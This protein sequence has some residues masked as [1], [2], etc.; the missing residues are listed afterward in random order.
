MKK[1]F[2]ETA[3][4]TRLYDALA[5]LERRGADECNLMVVDGEP[6][7]GKTTTLEWW[8]AQNNLIFLRALKE[9]TPGWFLDDL[10]A[11]M[12]IAAP[13][14]F[15]NRYH[16]ALEGLVTRQTQAA[17]AKR[18]FAVVIDEADHISRNGRI[19]E[20]I[21]DFSDNS[22]VVFVL[23][24]MGKIRDNLTAFPQVASRITR[25]VRF[26]PASKKDVRAL[27]DGLCEVPVADDV[28]EFVRAATGGYSREIKEAIAVIERHG[29]RANASADK[30]VRLKDLDGQVLIYD[31]R[32]GNEIRV[33]GGV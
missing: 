19:I 16:R 18:I 4:V 20:T 3:N 7:L 23:V 32:T 27:F 25:Y 5:A 2:V 9:W 1:H 14:S 28:L 26:E 10:L 6:G 33:R 30:P 17:L 15:K 21:R 11:T 8:A 22:T 13:H 29:K 31:R 24:G 12:R